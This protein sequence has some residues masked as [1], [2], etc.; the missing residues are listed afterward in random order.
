MSKLIEDMKKA[1]ESWQK[2]LEEK[3]GEY[4]FEVEGKI[5][6]DWER[7]IQ[8][9]RELGYQGARHFEEIFDK[10]LRIL[11]NNKVLVFPQK[12]S[13]SLINDGFYIEP[14]TSTG[15]I[16]HFAEEDELKKYAKAWCN[17]NRTILFKQI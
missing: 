9:K 14:L 15:T 6:C 13:Y 12:D 17:P 4:I 16:F 5:T 11:Q 2:D 1:H 3:A 10:V 7:L 8:S